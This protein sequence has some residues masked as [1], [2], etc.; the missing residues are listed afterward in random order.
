DVCSSDLRLRVGSPMRAYH[1]LDASHSAGAPPAREWLASRAWY[2]R[3]GEPS[4]KRVG[5][6]CAELMRILASI[7]G[8]KPVGPPHL[9]DARRIGTALGREVAG[10]GLTPR[11]PRKS[12]CISSRT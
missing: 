12:F 7:P 10:L 1:A 8:G 6:L 3:I 9:E 11:R 4:R 5:T 2:A